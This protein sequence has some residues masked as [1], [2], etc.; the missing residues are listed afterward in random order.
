MS[1]RHNL[2]RVKTGK[3]R[4]NIL[5]RMCFSCQS[6]VVKPF[7][8]PSSNDRRDGLLRVNGFQCR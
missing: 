1:Q 8:F 2:S 3:N 5:T 4:L 6:F 7:F